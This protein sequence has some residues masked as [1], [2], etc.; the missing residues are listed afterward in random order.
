M[1]NA[2]IV[3]ADNARLAG[4]EKFINWCVK[5]GIKFPKL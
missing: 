1:V 2:S 4:C 3:E 5:V